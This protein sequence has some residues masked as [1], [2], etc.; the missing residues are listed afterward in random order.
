MFKTETETTAK[1]IK[2]N[3]YRDLCNIAGDVLDGKTVKM[4]MGY[5]VL[6]TKEGKFNFKAVAYQRGDEI[7]LCF[8]GT[9][10]LS[11]KDHLTNGKM[12]LSSKP[13]EQMQNALKYCTNLMEKN[14]TSQFKVIGHSEGGSEALYVGLSKE[15]PTITFNAY[16]LHSDLLKTFDLVNADKLI[17]NYRDQNDPVSK[18]RE[19]PGKSYIVENAKSFF[20]KINP[21]G[22]ISAHRMSNFGDCN[23]AEPLEKYKEEHKS[24]IS[25]VEDVEITDKDIENMPNELYNIYDDVISTRLS[26]GKILKEYQANEKSLRGDLVKVSAYVRDDGTQVDGYYRRRPNNL[27][28]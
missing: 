7:I 9:D 8:L 26:G 22:M 23:D 21:F 14:P 5:Q 2:A 1:H 3:D 13:T 27:V 11:L 18:V 4:P 15:V 24:F 12:I 28:A 17:T 25:N 20:K 6:E 16:G 10:A 19:L